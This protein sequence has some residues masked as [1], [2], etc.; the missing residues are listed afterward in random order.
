MTWS[1]HESGALD[2][3]DQTFR[4][5]AG[6]YPQI[7]QLR[8]LRFTLSKLRLNDLAVGRDGRNRTLLSPY[9][10]KTARNTPSNKRYVFGPAKWIRFFIAPPPGYG[11]IHRDFAQQEPRIAAILSG[12]KALLHACESGD[13][14]LGIAQR[15]GFLRESM[16]SEERKGVRTLFKTVV[17][18]IMYGLGAHSLAMRTGVS[19]YE[20]RE[21]LARLRAQFR[22]FEDY[23]ESVVDHA[24][25]FGELSTQFGWRMRCPPHIKRR[26]V[27]NYPIQSTGS[28]ILHV[29]SI[30]AERRQIPIIAPIHD[31]VLAEA[32]LD[33]LEETS[34]ALD[35]VMR[36][37][38]ALVLKGYELPTEM[39]GTKE[40]GRPI[41]PGERYYDE[42]GETMWNTV[43]RLIEKLERK[44]AQ[45]G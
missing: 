23:A 24:G 6:R 43:S 2:L 39:G 17:L 5:M 35:R 37:A 8:E 38:S 15:L 9:G 11:L 18:G 34:I 19:L 36:D 26:T 30:V 31:A 25:L 7:E 32:P 16:S 29:A 40:G 4:E 28:E 20:A 10:T 14:Y 12:D 42:R 13:V 1:R 27:R 22:T 21:I 41:V 33:R 45:N 44:A 3:R